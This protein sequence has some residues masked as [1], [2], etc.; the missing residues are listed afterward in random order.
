VSLTVHVQAGND[1][2]KTLQDLAPFISLCP[3]ITIIFLLYFYCLFSLQTDS[4]RMMGRYEHNSATV[5][6]VAKRT[7]PSEPAEC[8]NM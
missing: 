6:Y 5:P 2:L 4:N 3:Y 1:L 8:P 7:P